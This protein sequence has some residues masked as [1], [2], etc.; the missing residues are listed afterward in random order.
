MLQVELPKPAFS[1][2]ALGLLAALAFPGLVS[3]QVYRAILPARAIDWR[4]GVLA[5]LFYSVVNYALGF[6]AVLYV[7][8]V[9][10]LEA[11]PGRY[12]FCLAY[13][14]L[15]SPVALPVLYR[16]LVTKT[17]LR[18]WLLAPY[19]TAFDYFFGQKLP[20]FVIVNLKGGGRIAGFWGPSGYA[21]S[22]PEQGD[23][24]LSTTVQLTPEG[25]F[26]EYVPQSLGV[27]VR[28]DEY[29]HLELFV[30][31]TPPAPPAPR[32]RLRDRVRAWVVAL[33]PQSAHLSSGAG[34]RPDAPFPSASSQEGGS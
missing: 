33:R 25:T 32:R 30:A 3:M 7:V 14:L 28:R 24:Y 8:D 1:L 18:R 31:G 5:A 6:W 12:W 19:P 29:T 34:R 23:L 21:S 2:D 22:F 26:A 27:L 15:F 20:C 11:H 17:P 16:W 13:L 4:D 9:R 10:H